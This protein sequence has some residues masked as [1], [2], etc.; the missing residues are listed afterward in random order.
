MLAIN[1]KSGAMTIH[2]IFSMPRHHVTSNHG[3]AASVDAGMYRFK[4]R[5]R[6]Y[7]LSHLNLEIY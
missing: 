4:F 2:L 6:F 5:T 3:A 7:V 1:C